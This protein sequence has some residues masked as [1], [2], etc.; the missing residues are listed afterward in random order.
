MNTVREIRQD[1]LEHLVR[2]IER[3]VVIEAPILIGRLRS[4][5][6][7]IYFMPSERERLLDVLGLRDGAKGDCHAK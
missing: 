7:N 5:N 6:W 3:I 4:A 1:S 2:V